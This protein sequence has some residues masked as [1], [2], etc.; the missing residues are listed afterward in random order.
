MKQGCALGLVLVAVSGLTGTALAQ[1]SVDNDQIISDFEQPELREIAFDVDSGVVRVENPQPGARDLQVAIWEDVIEVPDAAWVRLRFSDI[2]LARSTENVRESYL[3]ITSLF[4][5]HEQYL[6]MKSLGEWGNTSA[7]FNGGAVKVEIMASPNATGQVNRVRVTGVQA[8]APV[9]G[10]R[11]ICGSVDDRALS[12]DNRDARLM[13]IGCTAWLFSDHG[14]R[15]MSAAHCGPS[16]G[17]VIQFNVPLSTSGGSTQN[18]PP[19][20]QYPVDNASVQDSIGGIFIGNDWAYFG[21]FDNSNTGM[22]P[23]QSYGVHHTLATSGVSADNRPIRITGYGSTSSPVPASWYLVQKTH[24]GPLVYRSGNTIR[25]ATDT[26]GGNSGSAILDENNQTVLGVHTNA[27]CNSTGGNQG[28]YIFNS[29]LQNALA[30]PQG[31][32]LPRDIQASVVMQ[33]THVQPEGGDEIVLQIDNL[34]GHSVVGAPKFIVNATDG[35]S[36]EQDMVDNGDGTYTGTFGSYYCGSSVSYSFEIEDEQGTIV[37]VPSAGSYNTV[38]LDDLTVAFEDNFETNMGWVAYTTGGSASFIRAEPNG[39]GL[40]DPDSD[41]DGSGQCYVTSNISGLDVDNGTV[42]LRS[43]PIDISGVEDGVVRL[44]VWMT[45]TG[46][47]SMDIEFSGNAGISYTEV[48]S[49]TSTNGS[50]MDVAIDL[51]AMNPAS[52]IIQ[53]RISVTDAGADTT[54]EGG[55]DAFRISSEVCDTSSCPADLTGDG[56][57]DFFDVSAF[58]AAFNAM[59]PA[60]D[61]TGDGSFDFFDVSSFLD[62]F[63][64]GCP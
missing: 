57:V 23:G 20:D 8:S 45:G 25:Y 27:G 15:M 16:G 28:T 13:P 33:P 21:V 53:L 59:D 46:P 19:Q 39:Y 47:D 12:Y 11:S 40:G 62:A 10:D 1:S 4:D 60:A 55:V 3:K 9:T 42:W 50:W 29:D 64:D 7:Y 32:C 5:G 31:I 18:P 14:S 41:A 49:I 52:N 43:P 37:T 34:Q 22:S 51:A 6:D 48:M 2:T 54:V 44:S 17:D 24:V 35:T 26:T 58:L 38:A 30:N 56:V 61:F 63:G 36:F